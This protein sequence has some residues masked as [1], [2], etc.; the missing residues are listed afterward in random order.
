MINCEPNSTIHK[1]RYNAEFSVKS[2]LGTS[3]PNKRTCFAL[4]EL[5]L[6]FFVRSVVRLDVVW[7]WMP[8][9]LILLSPSS[10]QLCVRVFSCLSLPL[11]PKFHSLCHWIEIVMKM[12]MCN[13][14][15]KKTQCFENRNKNMEEY[16]IYGS[17]ALL[18]VCAFEKKSVSLIKSA[19]W[20]NGVCVC[21]V[22]F[23]ASPIW[24]AT[25]CNSYI[26]NQ[27][28]YEFGVIWPFSHRSKYAY[29]DDL[30]LVLL[31][32]QMFCRWRNPKKNTT[33]FSFLVWL[34]NWM[35]EFSQR[36]DLGAFNV[37]PEHRLK[38]ISNI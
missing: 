38:A 18:F 3:N 24:F 2:T 25:S 8:L 1:S 19:I 16:G 26:Y 34:M 33:I 10:R 11:S 13:K 30:L 12:M 4:F 29:R 15:N 7:M 21:I 6:N 28:L 27:L 20:S 14:T 23:N 36:M 37:R 31:S 5:V 35:D 17:F 22:L 32:M 9:P